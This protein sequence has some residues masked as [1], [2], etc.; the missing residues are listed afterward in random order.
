MSSAT[1]RETQHRSQ[2]VLKS[3]RNKEHQ[4]A[5]SCT[6]NICINIITLQ[7]AKCLAK[8]IYCYSTGSFLL[9][10]PFIAPSASFK[11]PQTEQNPTDFAYTGLAECWAFRA[12]AEGWVLNHTYF[13]AVNT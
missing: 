4:G 10:D 2:E 6:Y 1:I 9:T 7:R 8:N 12:A 11:H 13:E 5:L 3:H